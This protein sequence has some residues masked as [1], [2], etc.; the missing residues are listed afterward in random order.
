MPSGRTTRRPTALTARGWGLLAAAGV[1]LVAAY[2]LGSQELLFAACLLAAL[3]AIA[4]TLV[5][6]RSAPLTAA[7]HFSHDLVAVGSPVAVTIEVSNDNVGRSAQGVWHDTLP[8]SPFTTPPARLPSL[9]STRFGPHGSR[10]LEYLVH[11][12]NRGVV[13]IGPVVM[14]RSDPFGLTV[15]R[16]TLGPKR[17]LI[18]APRVTNLAGSG[19][20]LAGG[21]GSV[22]ASRRNAAG[23]ND[24]LMTREYRRGDALRRVHWRAT[25]RHGDLMVRQEEESSFPTARVL[26]DTRASGYSPDGDDFEWALSMVASLGVHLVGAGFLLQL[27]ESGPTQLVTPTEAGG[28]TGHDMEFLESLARTRLM[29]DHVRADHS[30]GAG[31]ELRGP[32]FAVLAHPSDDSLQWIVSQRDRNEHGIAL[33]VDSAASSV[34]GALVRAGW[35]CISVSTTD[36]PADVWAAA[37]DDTGVSADSLARPRFT[38]AEGIDVVA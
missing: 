34:A 3:V 36:D 35:Q 9:P 20:S 13:D 14:E 16:S 7:R 5:R 23:T 25:A 37:L 33:V 24:D 2:I 4:F 12:P 10:T 11:P 30:T 21:D 6:L 18:V 15:H 28:G 32:L 19:F 29:P 31:A 27:R 26:L 8:W 1:L 17:Q 22:R 38:A